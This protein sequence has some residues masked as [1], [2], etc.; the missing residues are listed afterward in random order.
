VSSWPEGWTRELATR[1]SAGF[2]LEAPSNRTIGREAEFPVVNAQGWAGDVQRLFQTVAHQNPDLKPKQEGELLVELR[3]E[4][5]ILAAEVGIGTVE[6]ITGPR[7]ELASLESDHLLGL[8]TLIYAAEE[9]D[10]RIL[11]AGIQPLSIA[12]PELIC[13]KARYHVLL[14]IMGPSWLWFALTASDQVHVDIGLD[15]LAAATNCSSLL[16][17][18]TVALCGNSS[19]FHGEDS[20]VCSGREHLMG[21]IYPEDCRHGM[22]AGPIEGTEELMAQLLVQRHLMKKI[23]GQPHP[24]HGPFIDHLAALGGPQADGAFEAFL[25]HEH[26][27]WNSS[28][29]RSAQGTLE[30]RSACQQPADS[31]MSATAL[32]LAMVQG[33]HE[34]AELLMDELGPNPWQVTRPWHEA[35]IEQ[36]LAAPE[37]RPGLMGRLLEI[38]RS[39][40]DGRGLDEARYLDPLFARLEAQ[41]NPAQAA[42]SKL[43][44]SGM[45]TLLSDM[46]IRRAEAQR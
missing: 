34:L 3:G 22:P 14:D 44:H 7:P 23:E 11:G 26:Y 29:P 28:R 46:H 15:E 41:Q 20:G 1:F 32:G 2:D 19:V 45:G 37:P 31:H 6:L 39:A 40:L 24:A 35:V 25:F 38:C 16:T 42:R 18:L 13:P 27:I 10:Q 21:Q 33:H 43:E 4:R 12:S 30:L 8:Q 36:G 17:A 5:F 9:T